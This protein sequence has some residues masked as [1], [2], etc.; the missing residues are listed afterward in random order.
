M[1]L[2][3]HIMATSLRRAV[4]LGV[5]PSGMYVNELVIRTDA[6]TTVQALLDVS[7]LRHGERSQLGNDYLAALIAVQAPEG[8]AH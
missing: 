6:N 8:R 4:E 5:G 1:P 7:F 3:A 2:V